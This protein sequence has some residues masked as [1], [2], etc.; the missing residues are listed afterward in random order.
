MPKFD[1]TG[2]FGYGPGSGWGL[3]PCMGRRFRR[4]AG[5]GRGY[6][7]GCSPFMQEITKTEEKELLKEETD[8]LEE[9]L[10]ALK[11]RLSELKGK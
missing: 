11:K 9:E 1:R 7:W 8:F 2:P 10:K 3:G 4:G 6:G 5:R